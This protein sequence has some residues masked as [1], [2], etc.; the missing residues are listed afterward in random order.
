MLWSEQGHQGRVPDRPRSIIG[1]S[2]LKEITGWWVCNIFWRYCKCSDIAHSF[3]GKTRLILLGWIFN[4]APG[5]LEWV[6]VQSSWR[7]SR[8]SSTSGS[9]KQEVFLQGP[10][11]VPYVT[12]TMRVER[13]THHPCFLSLF[14]PVPAHVLIFCFALPVLPV[15]VGPNVALAVALMY[16]TPLDLQPQKM[17]LSTKIKLKVPLY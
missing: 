9:W 16:S 14:H 15:L 2:G 6:E 1:A 3:L 10:R 4:T 12:I 5:Q 7:Y 13:G 11:T 8:N 17:S